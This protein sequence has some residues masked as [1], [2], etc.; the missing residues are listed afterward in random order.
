MNPSVLQFVLVQVPIASSDSDKH[1]A[2]T[3][4]EAHCVNDFGKDPGQKSCIVVIV[5]L[6]AIHY[7][8]CLL[9]LNAGVVTCSLSILRA[10]P[11]STF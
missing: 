1:D 2:G 6:R 4:A 8:I 11:A 10:I 5:G 3:F 7:V 9:D